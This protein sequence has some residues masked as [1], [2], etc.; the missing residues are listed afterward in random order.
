MDS[1]RFDSCSRQMATPSS[2]RFA[3]RTVAVTGLG[4]GLARFGLSMADAKKMQTLGS[5]GV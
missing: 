3:L 4:L 5:R 1:T 2:R